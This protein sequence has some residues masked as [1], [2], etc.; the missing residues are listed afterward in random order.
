MQSSKEEQGEIKPSSVNNAKEY[1]R[2]IEWEGLEI[3]SRN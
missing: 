2:T 1:R 3:S